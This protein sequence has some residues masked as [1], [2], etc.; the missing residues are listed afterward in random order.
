VSIELPPLFEHLT[1]LSP[2]SDARADQLVSWLAAGLADGGTVL[3]VGCGWGELP[4]RVA[5]A[6]PLARV[7]GIDLDEERIAEAR[8]RTTDR[9]LDERATFLATDG[10]AA[11]PSPVDGLVA[12]GA[13]QVWGP[14]VTDGHPLDYGSALAAMRAR[15]VRGGRVVYADA[16]WSRSP[17]PEATAPLSGRDDEFV[18]LDQLVDLAVEH[19]FAVAGVREAS[20]DEWDEFES[21]YTARYATWLAQHDPGHPD[22]AEVRERA[23]RQRSGYLQGYRGVLGMAY[24][25][26]VAV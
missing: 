3:D 10:L 12:I 23:A 4:L 11:G 20:L 21:G 6:A 14:A 16:I 26:L 13:T 15:V 24:L 2:L 8:R 17:T 9:R 25:Q 7:I 1:F 19:G 22:A 5:A 18:R